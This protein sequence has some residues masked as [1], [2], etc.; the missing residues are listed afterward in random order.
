V[1]HVALAVLVACGSSGTKPADAPRDVAHVDARPDARDAAGSGS[2]SA[3]GSNDGFVPP[4]AAMTAWTGSAGSYTQVTPDLSCL[5]AAR[6]DAATT[7]AVTLTVHARDFQSGNALQDGTVAAYTTFGSP[8]ST[9]TINSGDATVTVPIGTRRF[10]IDIPGSSNGVE[11]LTVDQL[12]APSPAAQSMTAHAVSQST[13]ATLPALVGLT[14]QQGSS[15][16]L[17]T[18]HDCAGANLGGAIATVSS[19]PA[20][21][22]HLVGAETFYFSDSVD[23]PVHHNQ[24]GYTSHDGL[25]M[26]IG[27]PATTTAY[28][29][30]WGFRTAAE[31]LAGTLTEIA[32]LA[33]PLPASAAVLSVQDPRATN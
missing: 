4:P 5:G 32:E 20:T 13:M 23:L 12:L 18:I 11:T 6:N 3:G 10:G 24:Q 27:L 1:R 19:T 30:V 26:V 28:V 29:Q 8:F 14:Y 2:G 33:V 17:G 25:F 22:M 16:V 7:V 9:G 15:T 31:Q 21:A